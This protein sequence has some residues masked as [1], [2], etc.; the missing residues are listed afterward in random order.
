MRVC[1]QGLWHLGSVTA[2]CLAALGHDV[3][4]YDEDHERIAALQAGRAPI[5]EPGLPELLQQGLAAGRLRFEARAEDAAGGADVLWVAY[6]TPVDEDDRADTAFV[7][8]RVEAM[9]PHLPRGCVVV[10]SS[11]LPVGS[12]AALERFA[13][14]NL[15][16]LKLTFACSPENLRLGK[17]IEVFRNPDRIVVG[18]RNERDR[19]R[20]APLFESIQ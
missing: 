4:G 6:D 9:L 1:V 19:T 5:L 11:Q 10:V 15:A 12:I 7:T 17:A 14:A 16:Q 3:A 8:S 13:V 2:A 20:V 18:T